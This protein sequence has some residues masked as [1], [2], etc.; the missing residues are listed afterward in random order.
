MREELRQCDD[1]TDY[2]F[3]E[4]Q[5]SVEEQQRD[6]QKQHSD[7]EQQREPA[8]QVEVAMTVGTAVTLNIGGAATANS[9]NGGEQQQVVM[10]AMVN[11]G[12][13]RCY[14]VPCSY[15]VVFTK[16][17]TDVRKYM[18]KELDK[19]LQGR[20]SSMESEPRCGDWYYEEGLDGRSRKQE[21][22]W[23]GGPPLG[24][25][26]PKWRGPSGEDARDG[27]A[28]EPSWDRNAVD[29]R[30]NFH[31]G[32]LRDRRWRSPR[33]TP[34][35]SP[36]EVGR[37][38]GMSCQSLRVQ[39]MPPRV[40]HRLHLRGSPIMSRPLREPPYLG[41]LQGGC[42]DERSFGER[43]EVS[44]SECLSC[45]AI[46]GGGS[47]CLEFR[48]TVTNPYLKDET[49]ICGSESFS[50]NTARTDVPS[51]LD[52]SA[53]D[54]KKIT[55]E[56][57]RF[58]VYGVRFEELPLSALGPKDGET[59]E[60]NFGKTCSPG[61][62]CK[63]RRGCE[64]TARVVIEDVRVENPRLSLDE[65]WADELINRG[66]RRY[67]VGVTYDEM[68]TSG[69]MCGGLMSPVESNPA[70]MEALEYS[71]KLVSDLPMGPQVVLEKGK[72]FQKEVKVETNVKTIVRGGFY[73]AKELVISSFGAVCLG[74]A[75]GIWRRVAVTL[76]RVRLYSPGM[77][78]QFS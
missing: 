39:A 37:S 50:I 19:Y 34:P 42:T 14:L 16:N 64:S 61:M 52:R 78:V 68:K 7:E 30:W 28:L 48:E 43:R 5:Y 13:I 17:D 20:E 69:P 11:G 36:Y 65:D 49:P 57:G 77:G 71:G 73:L 35:G 31:W 51:D 12:S 66:V 44:V 75:I 29:D 25:L 24:P 15:E 62:M 53:Q 23:H 27:Y 6:H 63:S 40:P 56:E 38:S 46:E 54:T 18:R 9:G 47:P 10:M 3:N 21:L 4:K 59:E 22:R 33:P 70:E 60:G 1:A 32:E 55:L 74:V 58:G 2:Y 76:C 41:A 45:I 67:K 8:V 26:G 72:P